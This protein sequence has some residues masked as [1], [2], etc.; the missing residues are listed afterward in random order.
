[1]PDSRPPTKV[2]YIGGGFVA[3]AIHLPNLSANPHCSLLA[4]A[5]IRTDLREAVAE[6]HHIPRR[7]A[8]HAELLADE[9][10]EAV[11]LSAPYQTQTDIAIDCLRS[12][13]PVLMEKPA[14]LT[15]FDAGRLIDA[16]RESGGRLMVAY[17]KRFDSGNQLGLR[18]AADLAASGEIGAPAYLRAH[19]GGGNW[20]AG[21]D[22]AW[23]AIESASPNTAAISR[24]PEW[25]PSELEASYIDFLQ[26]YSHNINLMRAFA[27][28]GPG[29][30]HVR[31]VD[32]DEDNWTGVV[33][34][35]LAGLR[36]VLEAGGARSIS[37]HGWDEHTQLYFDHGW[38][39]VDGA[40]LQAR[41]AS[42]V[43]IYRTRPSVES[44]RPVPDGVWTSAYAREV[45]AFLMSVSSGEPF[46]T[47]SSDAAEDVRLVEEVYRSWLSKLDAG[48]TSARGKSLS[49]M[50]GAIS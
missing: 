15:F 45:D 46:I 5:E 37:H 50:P 18:F 32:F 33:V 27:G 49:T 24:C 11:A 28:V 25:L 31:A 19:S 44:T 6:R 10:I 16:E 48:G 41:Q 26:Q 3:Q 34:F 42:A 30:S 7:Y 38:V 14:A 13:R 1:L 21:L 43:E 36:G 40:P 23:R 2:G 20:L 4:I 12:G 29:Q 8:S 39:R 17:M 35:D 47:S 22:P 9:E